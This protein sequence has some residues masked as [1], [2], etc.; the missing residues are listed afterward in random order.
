MISRPKGDNHHRWVYLL[1]SIV[2]RRYASAIVKH[3]RLLAFDAY[4]V[5]GILIMGARKAY[6]VIKCAVGLF[7][8]AK[9]GGASAVETRAGSVENLYMPTPYEIR[10]PEAGAIE[11]TPL[12]SGVPMFVGGIIAGLLNQTYR[13]LFPIGTASVRCTDKNRTGC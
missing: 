3:K 13:M 6:V 4:T 12:P 9:A 8:C 11:I 7:L 10:V 2:A 1:N 5:Y